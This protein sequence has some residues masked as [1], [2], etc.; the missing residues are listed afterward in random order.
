MEMTRQEFLDKLYTRREAEA[1]VQLSNVAFQY[2]LKQDNIKPCK[3]A[4][5][6]RGTVQLFWKDDLDNLINYHMNS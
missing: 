3:V 1:Y 2:H 6:G 4:G 5:R